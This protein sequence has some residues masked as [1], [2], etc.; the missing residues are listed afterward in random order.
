LLLRQ[1]NR[2]NIIAKLSLDKRD[3]VISVSLKTT[4]GIE[5][6]K[7][8]WVRCVSK[9]GHQSIYSE[10]SAADFLGLAFLAGFGAAAFVAS[11]FAF[12]VASAPYVL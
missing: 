7:R 11:A 9:R 5:E 8:R 2:K 6:P 12:R 10:S 3:H 4:V 1:F